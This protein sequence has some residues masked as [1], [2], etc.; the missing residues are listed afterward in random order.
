MGACLR[1]KLT[2]TQVHLCTYKGIASP[3]VL[4]SKGSFLVYCRPNSV[5]KQRICD[6]PRASFLAVSV[7]DRCEIMPSKI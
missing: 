7:S 2:C 4:S 3:V 1:R 6:G 5:T